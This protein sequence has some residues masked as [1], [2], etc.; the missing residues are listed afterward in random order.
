MPV[1]TVSQKFI[2]T[3]VREDFQ[4]IMEQTNNDCRSEIFSWLVPRSS[5]TTVAWL[6]LLVLTHLALCWH[7]RCVPLSVGR[8]KDFGG[9][10]DFHRCSCWTRFLC[11]LQVPWSRQFFLS[12]GAVVAAHRR[13]STSHPCRRDSSPW[14]RLFGVSITPQ[15]T[16]FR[17]AKVCSKWLQEK[18]TIKSY[19]LTTS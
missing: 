10:G 17:G 1:K 11:V 19:S 12:G 3:L 2:S 5:S 18:V 8:P 9:G 7:S 15:M 13:S 6:V 14:S 16:C 4:R